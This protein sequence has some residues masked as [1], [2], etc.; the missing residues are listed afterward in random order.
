MLLFDWVFLLDRFRFDLF[1]FWVSGFSVK[2]FFCQIYKCAKTLYYFLFFETSHR[3]V[4]PVEMS[5][6]L[7]WPLLKNRWL[8][9]L[10]LMLL[11][12]IIISG[13]YKNKIASFVIVFSTLWRGLQKSIGVGEMERHLKHWQFWYL[14]CFDLGT[15]VIYGFNNGFSPQPNLKPILSTQTSKRNNAALSYGWLSNHYFSYHSV[16]TSKPLPVRFFK[17]F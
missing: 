15:S 16:T 1:L 17:L 9:S 4:S 11:S 8:Y 10:S 6:I 13:S 2:T 5:R 3:W 12:Q 7:L 14:L